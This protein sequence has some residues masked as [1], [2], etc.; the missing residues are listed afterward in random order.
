M[1]RAPKL[2]WS[3]KGTR[4]GHYIIQSEQVR[5]E[6]RMYWA[7]L[8]NP[9]RAGR[10]DWEGSTRTYQRAAQIDAEDHAVKATL[11]SNI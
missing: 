7:I 6:P 8:L 4:S 1:A 11:N 9:I 5:G 3:D 2:T 10:L